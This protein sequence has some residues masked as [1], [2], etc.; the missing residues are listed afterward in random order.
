MYIIPWL[1]RNMPPP[2]GHDTNNLSNSSAIKLH[3]R[4]AIEIDQLGRSV[5]GN[6]QHAKRNGISDAMQE[7]LGLPRLLH[8]ENAGIY[9]IHSRIKHAVKPELHL[10][11][12]A[13]VDI[14]PVQYRGSDIVPQ[15]GRPVMFLISMPNLTKYSVFEK[16]TSKQ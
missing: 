9:E 10:G 8:T 15:I 13:V 16:A 2:F 4:F 7:R 1:N 11:G 14:F 6:R 12:L 3:Q 5:F